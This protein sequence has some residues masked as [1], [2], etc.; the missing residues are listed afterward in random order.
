MPTYPYDMTPSPTS[1]TPTL[2][3]DDVDNVGESSD[4]IQQTEE[5]PLLSS[6]P[7]NVAESA[8]PNDRPSPYWIIAPI[9]IAGAAISML[10]APLL[11]FYTQLICNEHFASSEIVGMKA[12]NVPYERCNIP[13]IQSRVSEFQAIISVLEHT[14][15]LLVMAHYGALSDRLGRR[16]VMRLSCLG[17]LIHISC[18]VLTGLFQDYVGIYLLF[19]G[20]VAKGLLGGGQAM[21]GIMHSY[22]SDC[23]DAATR[24]IWFGRFYG[25]MYLGIAIGP[26]LGSYLIK[27]FGSVLVLIY[28]AFVADLVFLLYV[29]FVLPESNERVRRQQKG[30]YVEHTEERPVS[31]GPKTF[32]QKIN[33]FAA[34]G[35]FFRVQSEQ[36]SRYTLPV[37]ALVHF[38]VMLVFM[39]PTLLY[40]MLK[41]QWTAYEGGLFTSFTSLARLIVLL[42]ILPVLVRRFKKPKHI[43]ERDVFV[44]D[45]LEHEGND[46]AQYAEM[47]D[48]KTKRRH[49]R[50]DAWTMRAGYFLDALAFVG[51]GIAPN[52][53]TFCLAGALQAFA[54]LSAPSSRALFTNFVPAHKVGELMGSLGA[55][56]AFAGI[57]SP[58]ILN[59]MYAATVS[60]IPQLVFFF[61][62]SVLIVA[63]LL[64]FYI[65]PAARH[66]KRRRSERM[67]SKDQRVVFD[68]LG[69]M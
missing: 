10:L 48:R 47:I 33:I 4:F 62:A 60:T 15:S 13:E 40:A 39:P 25:M 11:Q 43:P 51:Y 23:T 45:N 1:D 30:L 34:F 49:I 66:S 20:P 8:V 55:L 19:L 12:P 35:I 36:A 46:D 24:S 18:F 68:G 37:L 31:P 17:N 52:V 27:Q 53:P 67:L 28:I 61:G 3:D 69:E 2:R 50:F 32:W 6:E 9:L 22:V 41:F 54:I 29:S 7:E 58:I 14:C 59:T 56:D 5:T 65:K 42:G 38:L 16:Y 21:S 26:S 63:S 64:T 57:L 44:P